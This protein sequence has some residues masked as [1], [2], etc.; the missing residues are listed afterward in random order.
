MPGTGKRATMLKDI[1]A[2]SKTG[3]IYVDSAGEGKRESY[4]GNTTYIT[5]A[6]S[7]DAKRQFSKQI[8]TN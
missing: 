4:H 3:D 5:F 8:F 7:N 1:F 2:M 6:L